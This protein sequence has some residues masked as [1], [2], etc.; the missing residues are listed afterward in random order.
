MPSTTAFSGSVPANY[1]KYLGPIL[2]EPYA[3]DLVERLR[4]HKLHNV[5]ELACGTGRLTRH[6]ISLMNGEGQLTA[7]DLNP[8]MLALAKQ[9]IPQGAEWQV[10]DAQELPYENDRFDHVICQFGVMFFPEKEKAFYQANRVLQP[11][12]TFIFNTWDSLEYNPR[13]AVMQRVL[14]EVLGAESPDFLSK[15]PYSFYD[16]DDIRDLMDK[17]G[18]KNIEVHIVEKSASYADPTDM[19]NGFI[20]GSPMASYLQKLEP[21]LSKRLTE[22]LEESIVAQF[23]ADDVHVPMQALVCQGEKR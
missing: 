23:G 1:D 16:I 18:F 2:F 3:L 6:L 12:G 15:G 19:I 11:G 7:T 5:L 21:A 20:Y 9:F 14:D 13:V 17:T 8:D 22:R 4:T 10:V